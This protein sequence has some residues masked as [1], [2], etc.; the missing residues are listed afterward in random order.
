MLFRCEVLFETAERES[1]HV[2]MMELGTQLLIGAKLQ[3]NVVKPYKL[4]ITFL[5]R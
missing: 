5:L 1:D 4:L 3:P 2:A